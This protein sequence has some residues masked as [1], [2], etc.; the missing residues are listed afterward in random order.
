MANSGSALTPENKNNLRALVERG[1]KAVA[2]DKTIV[3]RFCVMGNEAPF[4]R[5]LMKA[6]PDVHFQIEMPGPRNAP[7]S[8]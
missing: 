4:I 8:I 2:E 3:P 7:N 5:E 1:V 6:Y